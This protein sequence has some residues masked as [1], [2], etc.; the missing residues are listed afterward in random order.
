MRFLKSGASSRCNAGPPF[1]QQVPQ[2]IQDV[3]LSFFP[4]SVIASGN[5]AVRKRGFHGNKKGRRFADDRRPCCRPEMRQPNTR[6]VSRRALLRKTPGCRREK[7]RPPA[8]DIFRILSGGLKQQQALPAMMA[9]LSS[10][11]R[12]VQDAR[13]RRA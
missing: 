1:L 8:L 6:Q 13:R 2:R 11:I 9:G 7:P 5:G 10:P 3:R 4:L 12:S